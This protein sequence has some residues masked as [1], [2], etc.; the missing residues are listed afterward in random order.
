M[1]IYIKFRAICSLCPLFFSLFRDEAGNRSP[2]CK[3]KKESE[4]R[5][6]PT[7][8]KRRTNCARL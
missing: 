3:S 2:I 5:A 1:Y 7:T 8:R 4:G 6:V